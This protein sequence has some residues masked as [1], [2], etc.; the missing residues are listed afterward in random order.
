MQEEGKKEL[1]RKIIVNLAVTLFWVL[2][3]CLLVPKLFHFFL[4]LMIAWV[5]SMMANPLVSFLERRI[6]IMRKHGSVIVIVLVLAAVVGLIYLVVWELAMQLSS[7]AVELPALY[8]SVIENLNEVLGSLHQRWDVI[9]DNLQ[10]IFPGNDEKLKEYVLSGL[11]SL[12]AGSFSS[13]GSFAGSLID[14][15][16]LS[17]L[18]IMMSYF[19]IADREVLAEKIRQYAPEGLKNFWGMAKGVLVTAIGGYLKAC[20]KIMFIMFLILLVFFLALGIKYAALLALVTAILDFLPFIGTGTVLMPWAVYNVITGHYLQGIVLVTAYFVT[21]IVRRLIEPKL[22]GDSIGMSP[23]VTLLS[24]FIGYRLIGML[25]L[26]LGIPAG[27][28]IIAFYKE[29][30]FD[31]QIRGIRILAKDINEYRKY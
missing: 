12:Q 15:L 8:Q 29:K 5:I 27:M 20:F 30:V 4:P 28:I 21:L 11:N 2:A 18:T 26:I 16:V 13:V 10:G 25:G 6:R 23:F 24:M 14:G 31:S 22:V 3:V 7:L 9:P 1:H 17:I 19:F